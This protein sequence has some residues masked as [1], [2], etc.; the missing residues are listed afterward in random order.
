[1]SLLSMGA[2]QR[3][4]D[5]SNGPTEDAGLRRTATIFES[6]RMRNGDRDRRTGRPATPF[7]RIRMRRR[8]GASDATTRSGGCRSRRDAQV[9]CDIKDDGTTPPLKEERDLQAFGSA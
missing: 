6:S 5:G 7:Q 2:H 3:I 4:K 8:N 9:E 1:M